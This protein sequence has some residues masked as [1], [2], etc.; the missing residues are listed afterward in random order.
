MT[1]Y[2]CRRLGMVSFLV[3]A[4][5][6]SLGVL[7]SFVDGGNTTAFAQ[8]VL[9]TR[10]VGVLIPATG[11]ISHIGE[12]ARGIIDLALIDFNQHL[13]DE[14]RGWQLALDIKD[15]Q[16][17][18]AISLAHIEAFNAD[19]IK[20][21]IGPMTSDS[22][23]VSK[24][25]I[26]DNN[27]LAVSY[28]SGSTGLSIPD[29]KIF[30]TLADVATPVLANIEFLKTD[31]IKH[32]ITMTIDDEIGNSFNSS[33]YDALSL[34]DDINILGSIN[35]PVT[36]P[37]FLDITRDLGA[38][39]LKVSPSD[40]PDVGVIIFDYR[41]NM[42]GVLDA[43]A[44]ALDADDI[45]M[46]IGDTK[47][48]GPDHRLSELEEHETV[49]NFLEKTDYKA[50]TLG[51][52][53]NEINIKINAHVN[54]ADV[55]TYP[56]YDAIF[57][58]G[59][60]IDMAG[61]ATDV[62]S[63][64]VAMYPSARSHISALGVNASLNANGDLASSDYHIYT[65]TNGKFEITKKY[66]AETGQVSDFSLPDVRNIGALIP[67]T[68]SLTTLDVAVPSVLSLAV[69][70]FNLG[71]LA[72]D[73][74]WRL[75]LTTLD[76][77]DPTKSLELLEELHLSGITSIVGPT[78]SAHVDAI[79]DYA[80]TNEIIVVSH[81]SSSPSLAIDDNI[82]RVLTSDTN[83]VQ[84]YTRLLVQDEI[85]HVIVLHRND[86]WG[87]SI[88]SE[89]SRSI[90]ELGDIVMLPSVSYPTTSGVDYD[91][92][93]A[94]LDS[95]IGDDIDRSS[96]VVMLFGFDEFVTILDI[97]K[98]HSGFQEST[99]YGY[100]TSPTLFSDSSRAEWL[101]SIGYKIVARTITPNSLNMRID[102]LFDNPTTFSYS[103]Y[104]AVAVLAT[105][106]GHAGDATDAATLKTAI[107]DVAP[108]ITSATG[109]DLRF[110]DVG[111]LAY[112]DYSVFTAHDGDL[113]VTGFYDYGADTLTESMIVQPPPPQQQQRSCR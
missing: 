68:G 13:L 69:E 57:V 87:V 62:D 10:T 24:Q 80:T 85:T 102:T 59:N 46:D 44:T 7:T 30:R 73:A 3:L 33:M 79:R 111:D 14:S 39:L 27:M 112:S 106:I 51:V 67:L 11:D 78:S 37:V 18:S 84:A 61:S 99:W 26:E 72:E 8:S 34:E 93:V 22:L 86:I 12:P 109:L 64:A 45:N 15:D 47:W 104:D 89:I 31:N 53:E 92:I 49:I 75:G 36:D 9:E 82:F 52:N 88:E 77:G 107:I 97:A 71:L 60:A 50:F 1:M 81:A 40:Y 54:N 98:D 65:L 83:A 96:V 110:N 70:D 95:A 19:G 103:M 16:G 56:A 17:I 91:S 20:V 66:D 42:I 90:S 100:L 76:A 6:L 101:E 43:V 74:D 41:G 55:Q 21:V 5:L 105:A 29:D 28:G 63:I 48:Y 113:V 94:Q 35:Y 58:L 38:L 4:G 25:Y 108:T 2:R 23:L 32:V